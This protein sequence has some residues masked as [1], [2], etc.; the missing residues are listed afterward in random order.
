MGV[1]YQGRTLPSSSR[2]MLGSSTRT[3]LSTL[4]IKVRVVPGDEG[5]GEMDASKRHTQGVNTIVKDK[6]KA[7]RA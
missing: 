6:Q 1:Q 3:R 2:C 7:R 5:C 4:S